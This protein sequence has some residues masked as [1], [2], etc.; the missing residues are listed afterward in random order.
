[1]IFD[2]SNDEVLSGSIVQDL[3]LNKYGDDKEEAR[4]RINSANKQP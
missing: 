1:M 3:H 4:E 2:K